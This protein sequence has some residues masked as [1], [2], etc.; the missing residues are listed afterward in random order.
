MRKTKQ[1]R[2]DPLI[3]AARRGRVILIEKSRRHWPTEGL[4]EFIMEAECRQDESVIC[5]R[6]RIMDWFLETYPGSHLETDALN[7][8]LLGGR[9]FSLVWRTDEPDAPVMMKLMFS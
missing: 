7:F 3:S 6:R 4:I 5:L 1:H 8:C 2:R 9:R